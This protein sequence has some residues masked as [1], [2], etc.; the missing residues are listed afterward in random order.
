M[1]F[2]IT[3]K[4]NISK[5]RNYK[6]TKIKNVTNKHKLNNKLNNHK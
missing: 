2:K 3:H 4:N 6:I 5:K 1:L